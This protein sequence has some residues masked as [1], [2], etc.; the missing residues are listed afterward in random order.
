[1]TIPALIVPVLNRFD[2]LERFLFSIDCEI[3]HILIVDNSGK[4]QLPQKFSHPQITVLNMPSNFGVAGSWNIG[5]KSFPHAQYWLI[6]SNDVYFQCGTLSRFAQL[7]SADA[8][9]FSTQRW[10][11]FSIGANIVKKVGLFDE[12]YHPAYYED[13]DYEE[14]MKHYKIYDCIV[15]AELQVACDDSAT[16]VK[17]DPQLFERNIVTN[18]SNYKYWT[19][20]FSMFPKGDWQYSLQRRI[21]NDLFK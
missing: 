15:S 9:L 14:R 12:N 1:M 5:I 10:G 18:E 2:L 21:D 11:C 17:S 3:Q 6:G 8:L 13:N 16:T 4:Y 20:K 7:S 19:S